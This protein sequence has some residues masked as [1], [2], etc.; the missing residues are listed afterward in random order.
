MRRVAGRLLPARALATAA[1]GGVGPFNTHEAET[2]LRALG[3]DT[4]ALRR[5]TADGKPVTLS[6]DQRA[7]PE[8]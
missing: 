7:A 2:A 5:Y 4:L 1:L 6:L 3:F 8:R